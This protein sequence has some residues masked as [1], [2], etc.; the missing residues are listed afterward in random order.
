MSW[1]LSNFMSSRLAQAIADSATTIYIDADEV[2]SLPTLGVSDKAKAVI[3]D[4]NYREIINITAWNTDGTLTVERA[5]ESTTARDWAAGTKIVH[6]PTA[7]ILQAVL[8]ATVQAVYRGTATG[9]NDI[10]VTSTGSVPTPSDGDEITFEVANTNTGAVNVSYTNGSTTIGPY[11]LLKQDRTEFAAGEL[12]AGYH[13]KARYDSSAGDFI[14]ITQSSKRYD[15]THI[16][17]GPID[18]GNL[19]PNGGFDAWNNATSFATPASG[20]ETADNVIATYDG[21]IGAFTVSRQTFTLGQTDVPGGPKYYLRWDQSSAGSASSFRKLR[22]K[23]PRVGKLALENIIASIYAKADSARTV[24]AK[25]IQH[26]GT[27]GAPSAEVELASES[28]SVTTSWT[29]FDITALVANINGK[30]LGSAGD[31]GLILE[32]GLPVNASMTLDFAMA[33]IEFG[34]IVTKAHSRYPLAWEQGGTGG[35]FVDVDDFV[36]YID[37]KLNT[38]WGVFNPDLVAIE[39]LAGTDGLLAKIAANSWAL[40][41]L[42]VGTGLLVANPAGIAGNPTVSLDTPLANYHADPLSV[43]ELASI[44]GNFGTA[45]FV[46]DNTLVHIAGAETITG[47]KV[48]DDG[49]A[50]TDIVTVRGA[51][52]SFNIYEDDAS[53]DEGLWRYVGVSGALLLQAR[54]DANDSG[55]TVFT[56]RRS[57]ASVSSFDFNTPVLAIDGTVSL[58]AYSFIGDPDT[59]MY[60]NAGIAFAVGGALRWSIGTSG[61]LSGPGIIYAGAGSAGGPSFSFQPDPD[62]GVYRVGADELGFGAGGGLRVSIDTARLLITGGND[63]VLGASAVAP[64]SIYSGGYRG[65]PLIGGAASNSAITFALANAG[66]TAYHDE[67]T[68]RTWTIPANASVAFPVGTVIIIDNTGNNGAAGTITLQITS[69]TL[70]RGDGT[71]GTGSRTIAAGQVA[72]IRKTKSTEWVITGTF[73]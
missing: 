19:L 21:T 7:E 64:T 5:Q 40:R 12:V 29:Q 27:G 18:A 3:F 20:T 30:T 24:T 65:A 16:N 62:T 32:L 51:T 4:A 13:V 46:A 52:P 60:Y 15:I 53:A 26:F 47:A 8:D 44:T 71:S 55:S 70:R 25:L 1:K 6:T 56:I 50:S 45:A 63:I 59:G 49:G 54:N 42:A 14:L 69:D 22:M 9:T 38:A 34:T 61:Q 41:N 58:P 33:Q 11:D 2:D 73:S 48:F 66:C 36:S 17:T 10:T 23:I 57:G 37:D 35:A 43:S 67:V 31:D 72:V 39:A 68:A 28:W